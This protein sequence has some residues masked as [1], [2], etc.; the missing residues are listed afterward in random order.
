MRELEWLLQQYCLSPRHERKVEEAYLK[1]KH[2]YVGNHELTDVQIETMR[3]GY[4]TKE[5]IKLILQLKRKPKYRNGK[6]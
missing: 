2:E 4:A 5:A 3:Q 1:A 6:W